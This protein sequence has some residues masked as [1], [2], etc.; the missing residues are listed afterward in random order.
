MEQLLVVDDD[1]EH[2]E[3]V[4]RIFESRFRVSLTDNAEEALRIMEQLGRIHAIISDLDLPGMSGVDLLE[5]VSQIEEGIRRVLMSGQFSHPHF[6]PKTVER[7]QAH[8]LLPKPISLE[9]LRKVV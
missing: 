9:R 4:G 6:D 1:R 3:T 7:A 8:E 5:R 2:L